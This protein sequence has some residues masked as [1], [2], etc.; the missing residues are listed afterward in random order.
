[1]DT[2]KSAIEGWRKLGIGMGAIT[3]LTV[4]DNVDFK[5][6]VIVGIIAVVGISCQAILDWRKQ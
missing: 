5:I 4:K 2:Q 3:A 6:A 1:M